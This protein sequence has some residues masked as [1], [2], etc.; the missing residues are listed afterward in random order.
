MPTNENVTP[1]LPP[2]KTTANTYENFDLYQSNRFVPLT[3][4]SDAEIPHY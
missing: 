3:N 1:T 2:Q 4:A